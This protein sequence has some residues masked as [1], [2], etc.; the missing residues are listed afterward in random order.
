[1]TAALKKLE[2]EAMKLP[3]RSRARL[4][5]RL[6][7]SLDEEGTDPNAPKLWVQESQRRAEELASG[8]VKGVPANKVLRRARAALR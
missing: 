4:A 7:S 8:R 5:E 3:T 6:I 1:M 2:D